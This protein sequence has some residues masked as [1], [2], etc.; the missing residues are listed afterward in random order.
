MRPTFISLLCA[1]ALACSSE[2]DVGDGI[3]DGEVAEEDTCSPGNMPPFVVITSHD[4]GA[5]VLDGETE[6]FRAITGDPDDELSTL[7]ADWFVDGELV[8][9]DAPIDAEG[10]TECDITVSGSSSV[11]RV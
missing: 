5:I 1:L 9:D 10:Q 8:C 3:A 7:E 2:K 11:I 6:T 4:D